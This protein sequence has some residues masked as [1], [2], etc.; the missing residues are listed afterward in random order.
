M[1][2]LKETDYVIYN[3]SRD[4]VMSREGDILIFDD[5]CILISCVDLPQPW[6]D[7]ITKQ[8]NRRKSK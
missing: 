8:I 4:L 3:K 7:V 2:K 1:K 5:E 6:K